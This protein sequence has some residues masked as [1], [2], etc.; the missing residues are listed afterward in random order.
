MLGSLS[1][2]NNVVILNLWINGL[3]PG[4][5]VAALAPDIR[6]DNNT[7]EREVSTEKV[8]TEILDQSLDN[9]CFMHNGIII[10]WARI[11]SEHFI[12]CLGTCAVNW[13]FLVWSDMDRKLNCEA[14]WLDYW[15]KLSRPVR[16][17]WEMRLWAAMLWAWECDTTWS[18]RGNHSHYLHIKINC[19]DLLWF[20]WDQPGYLGGR[21]SWIWESWVMQDISAIRS[22][23]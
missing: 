3:G 6:A 8:I 16:C 11:K 7:R 1:R 19:Q 4:Q 5:P 18:G 20:L 9:L 12:P 15:W 21:G 13:L 10:N 2:D 22:W 23:R 17:D 14:A